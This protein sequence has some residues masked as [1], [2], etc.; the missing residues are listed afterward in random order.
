MF[1]GG[2][3]GEITDIMA[4]ISEEMAQ[5]YLNAITQ[6]TANMEKEQARTDGNWDNTIVPGAVL[7]ISRYV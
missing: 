5:E 6:V 1:N 4:E 2:T 3:V 7:D